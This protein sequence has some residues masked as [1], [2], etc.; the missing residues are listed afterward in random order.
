VR[1]ALKGDILK[2]PR[3][4]TWIA[5]AMLVVSGAL[6]VLWLTNAISLFWVEILVAFLFVLF[7]IAQ[8][9]DLELEARIVTTVTTASET[10]RAVKGLDGL[11]VQPM[12][13]DAARPNKSA[14]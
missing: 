8:T 10:T 7:W 13:A 11:P 3:A 1:H 5:I 12:D 4:Y 14:P 2:S 9:I 6:I